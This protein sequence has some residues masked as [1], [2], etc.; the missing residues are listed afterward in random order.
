MV[1]ITRAVLN[2][3]IALLS[4]GP[5]G[6]AVEVDDSLPASEIDNHS[7]EAVEPQYW[8]TSSANTYCGWKGI[9]RGVQCKGWYCS[10]LALNC[11]DYPNWDWA[12]QD[13]MG[14]ISDESANNERK[15]APDSFISGIKC[16]GWYCDNVTIECLKFKN[17]YRNEASCSWS[18]YI[19]EE[20]P[21]PL[22]ASPKYLAGVK[23][24]GSY[25]DNMKFYQCSLN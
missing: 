18:S 4:L 12:W 25:C 13:Y 22:D 8:S 9:A 3:A 15:C 19:S 5:V 7:V 14:E 1:N 23:C 16:S 20:N 11:V 2:V 6:C 24:S 10:E 21:T 17:H